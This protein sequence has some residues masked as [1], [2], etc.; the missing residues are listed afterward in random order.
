MHLNTSKYVIGGNPTLRGKHKQLKGD[1][2]FLE[3]IH[4]SIPSSPS[5]PL[6][7]FRTA[8]TYAPFSR[9]FTNPYVF[10][11][12]VRPLKLELSGLEHHVVQGTIVVLKCD[13]IGA[14]PRANITWYNGTKA[15]PEGGPIVTNYDLQARR[16]ERMCST[17]LEHFKTSQT[18]LLY[19]YMKNMRQ[20]R[21]TQTQPGTFQSC[22][23][24]ST[25]R[26]GGGVPLIGLQS[27]TFSAGRRR[28]TSA[29]AHSTNL[30]GSKDAWI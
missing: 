11:D 2:K 27:P 25:L 16:R 6:N 10:E 21:A 13:V 12:Q 3:T 8:N 14:R 5:P 18:S 4:P 15:L 24:Q 28:K 1:Y 30:G 23:S 7:P 22:R 26:K 20:L 17:Q 29:L 19:P 9:V